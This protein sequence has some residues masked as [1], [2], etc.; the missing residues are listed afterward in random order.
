MSMSD[1]SMTALERWKELAEV[2][3]ERARQIWGSTGGWYQRPE[4]FEDPKI[5]AAR[6]QRDAQIAAWHAEGVSTREISRRTG[7]GEASVA[8]ILRQRRLEAREDRNG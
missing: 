7:L 5:T 2:E 6:K 8:R 4:H 3:N 1:T